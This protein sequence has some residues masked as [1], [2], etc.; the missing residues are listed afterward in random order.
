MDDT[1]KLQRI[2]IHFKYGF[3]YKN[4]K[5]RYEGTIKFENENEESFQFKLTSEL[6]DQY[7]KLISDAVT[8]SA[9][10]LGEKIAKSLKT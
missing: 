1:S 3:S 2:E 7:L 9:S 8:H 6:C 10:E 5:D 4:T